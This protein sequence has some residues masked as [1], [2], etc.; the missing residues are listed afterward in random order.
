MS[1]T[2]PCRAPRRYHRP[3]VSEVT[4]PQKPQRKPSIA[5]EDAAKEWPRF[6]EERFGRNLSLSLVQRASSAIKRRIAG[7]VAADADVERS[8]GQALAANSRGI[9]NLEESDIYLFPCGM[10][11]IFNV[12]RALMD[13]G[14]PRKSIIL[15]FTYVDTPKVLE[16]FGPGLVFYGHG[17]DEELDKLEERLRAGERFMALFCEIPSNPLLS[18]PDL[19]RVRRLA[20]E[21]DFVVV[22]DDTIGT[23]ANINVLPFAEVV[24]SSLTKIFSGDCN[25]MGGSALLN[26]NLPR[27]GAIKAAMERTFEDTYW[28]EDVVFMERNSRDFEARVDRINATSE[29][30]CDILKTHPCVK[31]VYYPKLVAS[32]PNYDICKLPTGGYG[33][34]FSIK[35]QTQRQAIAFYDALQTAKGPSLGT[36]FTLTSPYVLIA[37]YGELDWCAQYGVDADLIR[38][39]VGLEDPDS[40]AQTFQ[41]GLEAAARV[42]AE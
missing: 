34:L 7:A 28:P 16:K 8:N 11:A 13:I 35:F 2:K 38:V 21:F 4:P 20:D 22:I 36:N 25:V 18:C 23:F 39:S 40:L 37:H 5:D 31:Q 41:H 1:P 42:P 32:R 33:G 17:S 6:L 19:R 30:L 15:G 27:Y 29:A 10:N 3:S 14:E 9:V 12:H 26:P 24:V